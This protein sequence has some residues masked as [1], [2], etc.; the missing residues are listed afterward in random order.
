MSSNTMSVTTFALSAPQENGAYPKE[1]NIFKI[2]APASSARPLLFLQ[3]Q[4]P[5][6]KPGDGCFPSPVG[7]RKG[8]GG[9]VTDGTD[10]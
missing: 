5:Q 8:P 10:H 3:L 1:E 6:W 7:P 9:E 4:G 2:E